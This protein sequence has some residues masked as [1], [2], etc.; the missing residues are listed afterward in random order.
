M[1][2]KKN[3]AP[4]QSLGILYSLVAFVL[5][6]TTSCTTA[7][8]SDGHLLS[9]RDVVSKIES[10]TDLIVVDVRTP[11]EYN[12]G[13]IEGAQLINW[14]DS[15]FENQINQLDKSKP[16]VVYCAVGGRS[17]KAYARL[18]TLG[19]KEVFDMKGGFDAWRK[20]QLPISK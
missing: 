19:F 4:N 12:D 10:T 8:Q 3:I 1:K 2:F 15:Q 11:A 16:I 14:N 13:H 6:I 17:G 5:F 7:D 18:K 20:E 9:P